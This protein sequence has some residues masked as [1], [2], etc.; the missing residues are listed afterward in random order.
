[1]Q[2]CPNCGGMAIDANGY[3]TQCHTYRGLPQNDPYGNAPY[4]GPPQSGAPYSGPPQSNAPYSGP[5]QSNAPYSGPP[6]SGATYG[7]PPQSGAPYGGQP[8]QS[9]APYGGYPANPAP[10][11]QQPTSGSAYQSTTYGGSYG[12]PSTPKKRSSFMVPLLALSGVLAILVV[13][14]V[15]VVLVRKGGDDPTDTA[16]KTTGNATAGASK[17]PGLVDDC[18][19]GTW[20]MTSYSENV[21]VPNVGTV[22]FK[23]KGTGAVLT[24]GADGKGKQDYGT[25]TNF[26]GDATV[27][28]T[29]VT[30][31]LKVTGDITYDF[32]TSS[33]GTMT[34]SNLVSNAK[35]TVSAGGQEE[36]DDFDGSDD[37]SKYTC[38]GTRITMSTSDYTMQLSKS[39]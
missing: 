24:F 28:G 4:S 31:N 7:S 20:K 12:A 14:I 23:L 1:V 11:Y 35:A 32:R 34:F 21:P 3:C 2:P 19:V 17:T 5:P 25:G 36:S 9:G 8:P 6:Q 30:I 18:V 27:S 26:A 33:S 39:S 37:P 13:A 16:G 29:S 10:M 38:Q 15:V 22:P